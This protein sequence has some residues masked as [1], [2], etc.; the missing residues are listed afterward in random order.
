[1]IE[2]AAPDHVDIA[3]LS[4]DS[5]EREIRRHRSRPVS[6]LRALVHGH[7]VLDEVERLAIRLEHRHRCHL[8]GP[9]L[10][11]A[12]SRQRA[13]HSP[14]DVR[15]RRGVLMLGRRVRPCSLVL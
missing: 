4:P 13:A 9:P 12:A 2:A 15:S 6:G 14:V 7:F 10:A 11:H 8:S 3:L 1:M 5:P